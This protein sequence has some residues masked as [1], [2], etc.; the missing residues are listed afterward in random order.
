M[1]AKSATATTSKNLKALLPSIMRD[2]GRCH[3]ER[4]DLILAAWP[5]L[6]GERLAPMT[7]AASFEEGILTVKVRNSSLLSLLAQHESV[8]LLKELRKK[9]P[10]ANIRNIRFIIG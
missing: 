5:L 7:K 4:P 2:I 3:Q 10:N 9:F 8:R 6:I 1:A